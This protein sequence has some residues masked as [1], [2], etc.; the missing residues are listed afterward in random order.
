MRLRLATALAL[1]LAGCGDGDGSGG[2]AGA[3]GGTAGAGG[4]TAG[5]G[6][7]GSGGTTS[8]RGGA[9]GATAGT[10]GGAGATGG[11]STG[12]AGTA[13]GGGTGGGSAGAGGR[14][15]GGATGGSSGGAAGGG[16]DAGGAGRG[17][18]GG[19]AGGASG[20][21]GRGGAAGSAGRGGSGGAAGT[22]G[23]AGGSGGGAG[24]GGGAGGSGG[25]GGA[26]PFRPCPT[27][28]DPCRIL[29]L[30]D[31]ITDGYNIPGGY[32]IDLFRR[33]RTAGKNITFTGS[34]TN[35]PATVDGVTFPNRHEGHSGWRIDMIDDRV[36][37][38]ALQMVPHIVLVMAGTNDAIQNVNVS[39]AP[40]RVGTLIDA[41]TAG[42]PDALI[43]VALLTPLG[44]NAQEARVASINSGLPAIVQSRASAGKHVVLV[45]MHTGFP[46]SEL[47]DMIHPNMTGYNRMAGVWYAAIG[48][49]LP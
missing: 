8:G 40:A 31:S 23:G 46:E 38:P 49:L 27:N 5:N 28:G 42:A 47:A 21:G 16:G 25:A 17:G 11:S 18:N 19:A 1:A 22:G 26:T 15:G 29:P 32:R 6:G 34:Q 48:P 4:A 14:G 39:T 35:G 2:T 41:L 24:T 9:G 7:G 44:D 33:A 45:D 10:S 3:G 43:V 30:G 36:P 13:G 20:A 12:G 37:S